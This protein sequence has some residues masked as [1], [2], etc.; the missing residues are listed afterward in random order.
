MIDCLDQL[1][2][3][4][5]ALESLE[6]TEILLELCG[7]SID[8]RALPL[9]KQRLHEEETQVPVLEERGYIRL[10][11]KS[12]QLVAALIPLIATLE[13]QNKGERN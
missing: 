4:Y 3:R 12:E 10:R 8:E 2:E 6:V 9:L 7:A 13:T 11:E 1:V 5:L